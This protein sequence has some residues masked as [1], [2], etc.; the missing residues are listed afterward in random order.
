MC[1]KSGGNIK[2]THVINPHLFWFQYENEPHS[3]AQVIES[4]LK[5]YVDE[6]RDQMCA[7]NSDGK[8]RR[9]L[10]V[11]VYMISLKKWIRA[12]IDVHDG[13]YDEIDDEI[14]VWAMDYGIPLKTPLYLV[15][16]LNEDLKNLCKSTKTNVFKGGISDVWP[17]MLRV[18]VMHLFSS[19]M[20]ILINSINRFHKFICN[21]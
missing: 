13:D 8:Y 19:S 17:I 11:A 10:Y 21:F 6:N 16:L 18:N 7:N 9:E 3:D 20:L 15:V 12:T 5:K 2:I 1:L 14:V 4:E